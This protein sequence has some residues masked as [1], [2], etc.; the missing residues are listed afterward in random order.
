MNEYSASLNPQDLTGD[1]VRSQQGSVRPVSSTERIKTVDVVR[2]VA[3]LGILLMNIPGFGI[4][5]SEL[6]KVFR[7]P[8]SGK[9]YYTAAIIFTFFEGTMRGLFSML[10]GAGMVLF[11]MNKRSMPG[12]APVAEYYYRRLLWLVFFGLFNA[13]VLLWVGDILFFYGLC[14]MLLVCISENE[15]GLAHHNRLCLYS[16]RYVQNTELVR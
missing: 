13:F 2:G 14:G 15:T 5:F 4:D 3:L 1:N 8:H 11:M 6:S 10:F 12:E 7:G 9:D 16:D